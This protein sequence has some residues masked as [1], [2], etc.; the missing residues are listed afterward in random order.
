MCYSCNLD[1]LQRKK[2][3]SLIAERLKRPQQQTYRFS[4]EEIQRRSN[5]VKDDTFKNRIRKNKGFGGGLL[6]GVL[7]PEE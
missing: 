1:S 4:V 3:A 5:R 6:V 7:V 2:L